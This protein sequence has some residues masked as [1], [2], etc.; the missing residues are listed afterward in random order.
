MKIVINKCFGGFGLS[1]LGVMRYA[2]LAGFKLYP[3]LDEIT[4]KV[5]GDRAVI[6]NNELTHHFSRV[7]ADGLEKS[8]CG[9]DW[10]KLPEGAYWSDSDLDRS[11]PILVRLVEEMGSEAASGRYAK[12]AVVEVPDDVEWEIDEYD[13]SEKIAEKHRTWS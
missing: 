3:W 5:Y 6:G 8:G 9:L 12:L 7:P 4:K 11:D 1:F 10:P 13:G 2:E